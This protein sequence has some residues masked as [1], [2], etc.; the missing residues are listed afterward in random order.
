MSLSWKSIFAARRRTRDSLEGW[1]Q[2]LP[3]DLSQDVSIIRDRLEKLSESQSSTD[4]VYQDVRQ[5][6][7]DFQG[8]LDSIFFDNQSGIGQLTRLYGVF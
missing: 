5:A 4:E 7:R 2:D 8:A 3:R 1:E 6:S